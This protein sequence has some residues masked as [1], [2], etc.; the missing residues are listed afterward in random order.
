MN[1]VVNGR[2]KSVNH[3]ANVGPVNIV[4]AV[5][6][7]NVSLCSRGCFSGSLDVGRGDQ[8]VIK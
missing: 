5:T 3:D 7:L 4:V 6:L 8:P 1:R 2:T